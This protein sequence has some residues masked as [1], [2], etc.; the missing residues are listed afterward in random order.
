MTK[1][2]SDIGIFLKVDNA[3]LKRERLHYTR[4]LVEVDVAQDFPDDIIFENELGHDTYVKVHYDWKPIFCYTCS[5]LDM[6]S[7]LVGRK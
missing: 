7:R 1:I 6:K 4:V 5:F 2:V 3:T